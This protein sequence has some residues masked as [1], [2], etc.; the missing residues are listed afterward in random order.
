MEMQRSN[1]RAD[2]AMKSAHRREPF[3]RGA[4]AMSSQN[5]VGPGNVQI[6]HYNPGQDSSLEMSAPCFANWNDWT[7]Q[8]NHLTG[9]FVDT[10]TVP[11]SN[12]SMTQSTAV[13]YTQDTWQSA[14]TDQFDCDTSGSL[15]NH[16]DSHISDLPAWTT[17]SPFQTRD[18][19]MP[20]G[21]DLSHLQN[22]SATPTAWF[23]SRDVSQD[24]VLDS[25]SQ[26]AQLMSETLSANHRW[27][28]LCRKVVTVIT[29]AMCRSTSVTTDCFF[30]MCM[31]ANT[32]EIP[33]S[34][35]KLAT[36]GT[37]A[38]TQLCSMDSFTPRQIHGI[39]ILAGCKD[40]EVKRCLSDGKRESHEA[41]LPQPARPPPRRRKRARPSFTTQVD[42]IPKTKRQDVGTTESSSKET[43]HS[44]VPVP[45]YQ[46][47]AAA[48]AKNPLFCARKC[49]EEQ[50]M[51]NKAKPRDPEKPYSCLNLCGEAFAAADL[52]GFKRHH[53][54]STPQHGWLCNIPAELKDDAG[55]R[56]C[57]VCG[58]ENPSDKHVAENHPK[59]IPCSDKPINVI[60]NQKGG[61]LFVRRDK[62]DEHVQKHKGTPS[63]KSFHGC[64]VDVQGNF[65]PQCGFC[66]CQ[67]STLEEK[68]EHVAKMHFDRGESMASYQDPWHGPLEHNSGSNGGDDDDNDENGGDGDQGADDRNNDGG[69]EAGEG[70]D[71]NK[72]ED[73]AHDQGPQSEDI[74]PGGR[75]RDPDLHQDKKR[76][77]QHN[78]RPYNDRG[79]DETLR[80]SES[81]DSCRHRSNHLRLSKDFKHLLRR[82]RAHRNS[83][84]FF[85]TGSSLL[86][87]LTAI[88][89]QFNGFTVEP[90]MLRRVE[91]PE[92]TSEEHDDSD[93]NEE[94]RFELCDWS[95]VET[96]APLG[97]G[98][99]SVV[100]KIRLSSQGPYFALKQQ[101]LGQH[102]ISKVRSE[103]K[104]LLNVQHL[105]VSRLE[106]MA[107]QDKTCSIL[108]SPVADTTLA[109]LLQAD[110]SASQETTWT[111]KFGCLAQGV[112][113]LHDAD[114]CHLDLKPDNVLIT[115]SESWII[116]DFGASSHGPQPKPSAWTP[117]YVA[118][119]IQSKLAASKASDIWSLGCIG[120]ELLYH[121]GV[122]PTRRDDNVPCLNQKSFFFS[123]HI[124]E[125][126]AWLQTEA[127]SSSHLSVSQFEVL[128]RTIEA[129]PLRRPSIEEVVTVFTPG[130]CCAFVKPFKSLSAADENTSA[131]DF[132]Y[133]LLAMHKR[134]FRLISLRP[135]SGDSISCE[136]ETFSLDDELR[137]KALSYTWG[138]SHNSSLIHVNGSP[139]LV[140]R[141]LY[142][143]LVSYKQSQTSPIDRVWI[144]ALCIDQ[145]NVKEKSHQ[146]SMMRDIYEKASEVIV[147]LG[148]GTSSQKKAMVS[149]RQAVD[150]HWS[151]SAALSFGTDLFMAWWTVMELFERPYWKRVWTIQEIL[152][153][154]KLTIRLGDENLSWE[155]LQQL[156]PHIGW[157]RDYHYAD[158]G[159]SL[160]MHRNDSKYESKLCHLL[161]N[162][163]GFECN[164]PRDKVYGLLGLTSDIKL[165][166]D[167]T[168]SVQDVYIQTTKALLMEGYLGILT[169]CGDL[170]HYSKL[171]PSWVPDFSVSR[172]SSIPGKDQLLQAW[173][174]Q[175]HSPLAFLDGNILK[176][177]AYEVDTV[178]D[179]IP[180]SRNPKREVSLKTGVGGRRRA[181]DSLFTRGADSFGYLRERLQRFK[182]IAQTRISRPSTPTNER[183][184]P[185]CNVTTSLGDETIENLESMSIGMRHLCGMPREMEFPGKSLEMDKVMFTTRHGHV[186][187]T[188]K[189][190]KN[191]DVLVKFQRSGPV[192]ILRPSEHGRFQLVGTCVT[193]ANEDGGAEDVLAQPIFYIE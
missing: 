87:I 102:E 97:Y 2:S 34:D 175:D 137:Y 72:N 167:Y 67:F 136:L 76:R 101:K 68:L 139:F 99:T 131:A 28:P 55:N 96:H 155:T 90:A 88:A 19:S 173:D 143:L 171:L 141:N 110:P 154:R 176:I 116:G 192:F 114:F 124:A 11:Y 45:L 98:A 75:R 89:T 169:A 186:G 46:T 39:A 52:H 48:L 190:V 51:A 150:G 133:P 145:S 151:Q 3:P 93:R 20:Q 179:L 111:L 103:V 21:G 23:E 18:A 157:G 33:L 94:V 188:L 42:I 119:E 147:W 14:V 12:S 92:D 144:D 127:L 106:G 22:V 84:G 152:V 109:T 69:G 77:R 91:P 25:S 41:A 123:E 70:D 64:C 159:K 191:R 61:R 160:Y 50:K 180:R 121:F 138:T 32:P 135:Y 162:A 7:W 54:S 134:E 148:P 58:L 170:G 163:R 81:D 181:A 112:K 113:A 140:R 115:S 153:A 184:D 47:A 30:G 100:D 156:A 166:P 122:D 158:Y 168:A 59:I 37:D 31:L 120:L 128:R 164:D 183:R 177:R 44:M 174:S 79:S 16:V 56:I 146:V 62:F 15:T 172:N 189:T 182:S 118:P 60:R 17:Q 185:L 65:N 5:S 35:V 104:L 49:T 165:T 10:D 80:Q 29:N 38:L 105:H 26:Q 129:D 40:D 73:D 117:K 130:P 53:L 126:S 1:Y 83:L 74:D 27:L 149:L 132:R 9:S 85:V 125:L 108:L 95:G 86:Q 57:T 82:R 36:I 178:K 43:A 78:H 107:F 8:T 66:G 71:N 6:P 24:N 161:V 13:N 63:A 142:D 193:N 187:L 4:S